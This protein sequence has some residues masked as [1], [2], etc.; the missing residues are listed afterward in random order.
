MSRNDLLK[1]HNL[2]ILINLLGIELLIVIRKSIPDMEIVTNR[3]RYI[4]EDQLDN[5]NFN[6]HLCTL[7]IKAIDSYINELSCTLFRFR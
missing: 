7:G 4:S 1:T 3:S 2:I 5:K 6:S